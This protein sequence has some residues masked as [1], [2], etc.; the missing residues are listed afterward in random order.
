MIFHFSIP[1]QNPER[2]ARVIA[3]LWGGEAFPFLPHR[4]ASWIALAGDDRRT[5]VECYPHD[6]ELAP[7]DEVHPTRFEARQRAGQG[8]SQRSAT[9][10]A[11]GT[12]LSREQVCAIGEREGWLTRPAQRGRFH[13]VEMWLENSIL[14]EVLPPDLLKEYL[15]TQSLAAWRAAVA[16]R[17][18]V[19]GLDE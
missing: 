8:G 3:E 4:N 17:A 16:D 7:S 18:A 14:F 15:Q 10:G 12:P 2:V 5:G 9:H 1:T 13:V 6:V 11:I 19:P